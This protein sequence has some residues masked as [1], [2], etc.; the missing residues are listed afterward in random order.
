MPGMVDEIA[1]I[2][3]DQPGAT[4]NF[5][6]FGRQRHPLAPALD[7]HHAQQ[8]LQL[9]DLHGQRRL[10][11]RTG[12]RRLAEI[13]KPGHGIEIAELPKAGIDHQFFKSS[14]RRG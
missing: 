14:S 6:P 13:A 3:K 12:L 10:A 5:H 1:D 8:F 4:G 2:G 7:Q 9:L 11:H